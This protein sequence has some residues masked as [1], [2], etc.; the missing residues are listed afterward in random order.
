GDYAAI[1]TYSTP[2]GVIIGDKVATAY[3]P[4]DLRD[5]NLGWEKT[6][7]TNVGL[8]FGILKNRVN[9]MT[10][11]YLSQSTNLLFNQPV[12]AIT[13]ATNILTNLPNSK[14]QNKGFDVQIDAALIRKADFRL[15]F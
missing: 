8:D 12:T 13:G 14:V 6:A 7:Q 15:G 9:V 2:G 10:N 11:F 4:D 1:S 5:P 3:Y